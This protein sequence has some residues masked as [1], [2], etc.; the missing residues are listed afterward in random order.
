MLNW[1]TQEFEKKDKHPD[2]IWTVG[3]ISIILATLAFF[4]GNIFFGIFITLA[5]AMIIMFSFHNPKDLEIS[6][7]EKHLTINNEVIKY[8]QIKQFWIDENQKP[9]KLILLVSGFFVPTIVLMLEGVTVEAVRE[10]IL[11]H[12]PEVFMQESFGV[13]IFERLGF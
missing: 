2:W 13:K 8:D 1:K 10:E 12:A 7:E 3:L 6:F 4:Y 5:G 9:D 11:K